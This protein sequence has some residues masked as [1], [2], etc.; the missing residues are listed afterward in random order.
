MPLHLIA[1]SVG[2]KG[3]YAVEPRN[4]VSAAKTLVAGEK[5]A[6]V[7]VTVR[8]R[9]HGA[10]GLR[11]L[12]AEKQSAEPAIQPSSLRILTSSVVGRNRGQSNSIAP[13]AN[14]EQHTM[15]SADVTQVQRRF[16][17]S[18]PASQ[19]EAQ[20]PRLYEPMHMTDLKQEISDLLNRQ[21]RLPPAGATGFDPRLSPAWAGVKLPS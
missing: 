2:A 8:T 14:R 9:S 12:K 7:A 3:A 16:P 19:N 21:A 13:V 5:P 15:A 4:R 6:T 1:R 20:K 17:R 18:L 10:T 11:M